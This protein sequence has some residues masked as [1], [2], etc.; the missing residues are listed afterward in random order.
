MSSGTLGRSGPAVARGGAFVPLDCARCG[1][2]RTRTQVVPGEG[3]TAPRALFVGE[4]PGPDENREGR[5]FVG[6]AGRILRNAMREAGWREDEV[7]ITNVVKCFPVRTED[8]QRRIRAPRPDEIEACRRHLDAEK[9]RLSPS[10]VVAL[11]RTAA[12]ALT[13]NPGLEL[14]RDH[15]RVV[16]AGGLRILPTFHPSGLH[17]RAGRHAA[18][19]ED[20]RLARMLSGS[21]PA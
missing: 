21:S 6:R 7:W 1:L 8:A 11:G 10:I 14:D 16:E 12:V 18:F 19:R 2:A 5:P 4:A 3:P 20:L 17:Y 9:E 13:G 15:G